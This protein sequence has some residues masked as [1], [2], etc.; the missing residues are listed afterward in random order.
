MVKNNG[1]TGRCLNHFGLGKA[2][3]IIAYGL[4]SGALCFGKYKYKQRYG[5]YH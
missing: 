1:N 4:A 2:Y 5:V 3:K